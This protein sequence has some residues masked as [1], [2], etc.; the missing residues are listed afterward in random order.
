M[1][2]DITAVSLTELRYA[3]ATADE[4][5]FGRAARAC[6]VTQPTLS[7]Q[8]QK[9]EK[10]LGVKLF[11]R[12]SKSVHL[13][14]V[15][16]EVVAQARLVLD[17]TEK[18]ADVVQ[19]RREPLSGPL[20]L[21][22]IPTLSPYLLPWLVPPLRD[23]FPRLQLVFREA[24]TSEILDELAH[25]RLDAAILALPVQAPAIVTSPLFDEP[26]WFV[27]PAE[28]PL[29]DRREV[30]ESDLADECVMLLDEGHC[31]REQALAICARAGATDDRRSDFR[32]TSIE[33]LR[34]MVASGM[35]STLLPAL[36]ITERERNGRGVRAIPF[37]A[38]APVRRMALA[39]R[40][41]HPRASDLETLAGF[42]REHMPEAESPAHESSRRNHAA[43]VRRADTPHRARS[44]RAGTE[45]ARAIRAEPTRRK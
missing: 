8:I 38:P 18:I 14:P 43:H 30:T 17:A 37:A 15:G 12:T 33:T 22:V 41:T 40:R 16:E 32:A 31:L 21:G 20:R 13:T 34:H 19:S 29:A 44:M 27:A 23:A 45:R 5:H 39:W 25:H 35:G 10:T 42:I 9:L 6:S 36:A 1:A 4:R 2:I 24:K 11:E 7:A 26:F 28:H 3:V